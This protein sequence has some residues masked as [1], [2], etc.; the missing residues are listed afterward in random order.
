M[1]HE[2]EAEGVLEIVAPEG[3]ELAVGEVIARVGEPASRRGRRR[4]GRAAHRAAAARGGGPRGRRSEL[5]APAS[6]A[7]ATA[8]RRPR[9]PRRSPAGRRPCT[10]SRSRRCGAA[11]R[12]AASPGPTCSP[13]PASTRRP[14]APPPRPPPRPPPPRRR[15]D[16]ARGDVEIQPQSRAAAAHRP[17]DGRVGEAT[18]PALPGADRGRHGRGDRAARRAEGAGG[19]RRRRAVLQRPRRQGLRAGAARAPARERQLPR[20]A[21]SSCT[22]GSTSAWRSP[23]TT[24]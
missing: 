12:G 16:P 3:S 19:R 18:V 1:T 13:P 21:P 15:A 6:P 4:R 14:R 11:A 20:R 7:R 5:T 8:R 24:R 17:P 2:A 22:R 9:S 23:P 10:T